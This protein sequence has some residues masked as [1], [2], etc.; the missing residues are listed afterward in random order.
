MTTMTKVAV[1]ILGMAAPLRLVSGPLEEAVAAGDRNMEAFRNIEA[2]ENYRTAYALKPD[3]YG[4]LVKLT[5]ACNNAGE[6]ASEEASAA[7]SFTRAVELA[8][9]LVRKH[10][11][12]AEA[13][14]LL[15]AC[16]GNLTGHKGTL[17]RGRLAKRLFKAGSRCIEIDPDYSPGYVVLG[18]YYRQM[19]SLSWLERKT[20]NTLGGLPK[21]TFEQS[22]R[23][24][25]TAVEKSPDEIYPN[26]Q[27]A[28]TLQMMGADR[29]AE[30]AYRKVIALPISDHQDAA[31]QAD[32][33]KQLKELRP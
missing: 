25:E 10:P 31:K 8:D 19:A 7:T 17:E 24:L 1:L 11:D 23:M 12:K 29:E 33:M 28:V 4:I 15:A 14:F 30:R 2:L 27:L 20:A 5:T 6:D 18:I 16:L 3:D 13:H 32:A 9:E 22:R 21:G 26:Y